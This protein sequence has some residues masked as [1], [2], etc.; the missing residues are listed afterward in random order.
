MTRHLNPPLFRRLACMAGL[1]FACGMPITGLSQDYP[2]KPISIIVAYPPGSATDNLMRPLAVALQPLLGQPVV[3]DNRPGA[4]GLLGTEYGARAKPDGYTLLAGSTTTLAA[5]E[6]LFKKLGYDPI[7]DFQPVAGVGA[8]SQ[9]FM[10]RAD[11]PSKDLNGFIALARKAAQPLP[12][13]VGGSSAQ[14]ALALLS[15]VA[16]VTLTPIAYKG[17]PQA[18]TDLI[19]GAIPMAVVDVGNAVPHIKSGRLVALSSSAAV[20]SVAAPAVPTLAETYPNVELVTW[21]ALVA[22]AGTSAAIIDKLYA[23]IFRAVATP[24]MKARFVA[25]STEIDLV[26]PAELGKRMQRDQ[27]RWIELIKAAGI[28][29]E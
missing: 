12:V 29:P 6:G 28:E 13:G 27:A 3:I 25:T 15:K 8:T 9:M 21:I 17:T 16:G 20:R 10:V 5:S 11:H 2:V 7:R 22:P 19:G 24:E 14:V 23:A 18:L 1:L 4:Q 26:A